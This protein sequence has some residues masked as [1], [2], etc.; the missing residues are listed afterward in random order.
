VAQVR[1]NSDAQVV[2]SR[3]GRQADRRLTPLGVVHTHPGSLRHPSDGD[4]RGDGKW[5]RHL[6]GKEGVFAIGTA[7]ALSEAASLFAYQPRPNVQCLGEL[8]F[9][10]YSLRYGASG[11]RPLAVELTIGPDLARDLHV[12]WNT[13]EAHAERLERL[14]R[15]QSGL[16]FEV[17][18]DAEKGPGLML[19]LPLA[20]N[21]DALR[22]LVRTKEVRYYL[23]RGGEI[24]EVEHH[25]DYVDRGVYLLLAELAARA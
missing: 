20:G 16:R 5:V 21:G 22:V 6:R 14:Y 4:L 23:D 12:V 19:T 24:L 25:D 10:W 9:S 2:A 13:L 8:R 3:I 17:V 18:P 1:F 11:Y 7:D 15:Q